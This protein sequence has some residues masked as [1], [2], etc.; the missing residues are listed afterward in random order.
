V[1]FNATVV[2]E[3]P[4]PRTR[5]C[6]DETG[7]FVSLKRPSLSTAL[8][9]VVPTMMTCA[10]GTGAPDCASTTRPLTVAV[11]AWPARGKRAIAP[12]INVAMSQRRVTLS[13]DFLL[14][15]G[16]PREVNKLF[17]DFPS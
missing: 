3:Y 12:A 5:I 14:D 1:R 15:I 2:G 13:K 10:V 9:I 4:I 11:C 16:P 17:N 6:L 8:P 7:T